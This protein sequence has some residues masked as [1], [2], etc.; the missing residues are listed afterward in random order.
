MPTEEESSTRVLEAWTVHKLDGQLMGVQVHQLRDSSLVQNLVDGVKIKWATGPLGWGYFF[1]HH[2]TKI[3]L[4]LTWVSFPSRIEIEDAILNVG[5][6]LGEP[7]ATVEVDL[8]A[9]ICWR[10]IHFSHVP[11]HSFSHLAEGLDEWWVKVAISAEVPPLSTSFFSNLMGLPSGLMGMTLCL[12]C[13]TF[14]P[15]VSSQGTPFPQDW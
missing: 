3:D 5:L 15:L 9:E 7:P 6:S 13:W 12:R 14:C 2:L 11:S 4:G 10:A 1:K 8:M